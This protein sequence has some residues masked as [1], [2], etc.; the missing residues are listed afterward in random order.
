MYA[1]L[2][3]EYDTDGDDELDDDELASAE[4]DFDDLRIQEIDTDGDGE[5]S[6][7]ELEAWRANK[8]PARR[9]KHDSHF[10]EACEE[11]GKTQDECR[12]QRG[13]RKDKFREAIEARFEE[14]DTD[15]DG[16]LSDEE[17]EAMHEVLKGERGD[18]RKEAREGADKNGD[19]KISDAERKGARDKRGDAQEG[20]RH[21]PKEGGEPAK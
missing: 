1:L 19:G 20:H 8:L 21:P 10:K 3:E 17:K 2:V 12:S 18:R 15:E 16:E 4:Q 5:I 13:D 6:D 9:K 14:F 7:E 11:M